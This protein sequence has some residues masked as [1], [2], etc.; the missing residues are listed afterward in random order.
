MARLTGNELLLQLSLEGDLSAP[1]IRSQF[2]TIRLETAMSDT[3]STTSRV[4]ARPA[5]FQ[6]RIWHLSLLT[7]VAAVAIVNIQDQRQTDPLLIA[8]AVAGFALYT[9]L[10]WLIWNLLQR[11]RPRV[12]TVPLICLYCVTMSGLFLTATIT[13]LLIEHAYLV[14]Y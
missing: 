3:M 2:L 5:H 13:Y 7:V 12:G 1:R 11:S 14:G 4:Q 6:M 9:V 10:G 8:V